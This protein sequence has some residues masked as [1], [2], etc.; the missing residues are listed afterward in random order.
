MNELRS[1]T[2]EELSRVEGGAGSWHLGWYRVCVPVPGRWFVPR[3]RCY[4]RYGWHR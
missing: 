2:P 1:L 4:W 3:Y